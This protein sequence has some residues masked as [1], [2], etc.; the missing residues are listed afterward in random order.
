ME[1]TSALNVHQQPPTYPQS[2]SSQLQNPQ[3]LLNAIKQREASRLQT[4]PQSLRKGY[5]CISHAINASLSLPILSSC[6][7]QH[8]VLIGATEIKNRSEKKRQ[9]ARYRID[10]TSL[11][12]HETM[13]H[14]GSQGYKPGGQQ[15]TKKT[16]AGDVS[17]HTQYVRLRRRSSLRHLHASTQ[18]P[19]RKLGPKIHPSK[20]CGR[21]TAREVT[22]A[23]DG[24]GLRGLQ[25]PRMLPKDTRSAGQT[26]KSNRMSERMTSSGGYPT[27]ISKCMQRQLKQPII[28]HQFYAE[29]GKP[30]NPA[31]IP[32]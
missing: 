1:V 26:Q 14:N 2:H 3:K 17:D 24:T 5:A 11:P 13:L 23:G 10:H 32:K 4:D 16:K 30:V 20:Q 6:S 28:L 25:V 9:N 22:R 15:E 19:C 21:G 31:I 29:E 8:R 18:L 27:P 7:P 12:G